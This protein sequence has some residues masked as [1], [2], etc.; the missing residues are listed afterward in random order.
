VDDVRRVRE[1]FD[2]EAQGQ[3]HALAEQFQSTVNRYRD[4]LHLKMVPPPAR[5][6]PREENT[7]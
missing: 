4:R 7:A 6:T 3:I 5:E 2:R 1:R